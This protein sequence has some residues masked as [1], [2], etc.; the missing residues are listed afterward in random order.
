[1][2]KMVLIIKGAE[3]IIH[4]RAGSFEYTSIPMFSEKP[5]TQ[6]DQSVETFLFSL[7]TRL[8]AFLHQPA[9]S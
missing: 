7:G 9:K 2:P 3:Q 5:C 8:A 6:D 4:A 1:M